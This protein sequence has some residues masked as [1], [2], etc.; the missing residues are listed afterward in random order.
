LSCLPSLIKATLE[1]NETQ[2][3]YEV[4]VTW[5]DRITAPLFARRLKNGKIWKPTEEV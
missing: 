5:R 2:T 1:K 4:L 3:F